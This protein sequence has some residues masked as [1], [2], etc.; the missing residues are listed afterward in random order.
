MTSA[1]AT[2]GALER[3]MDAR[4]LNLEQARL[5]FNASPEVDSIA[6]LPAALLRAGAP[7]DLVARLS[8][9]C[10][11]LLASNVEEGR[12]ETAVA[13]LLERQLSNVRAL[14]V[15]ERLTAKSIARRVREP[16]AV[17]LAGAAEYDAAE[18]FGACCAIREVIAAC[19]PEQLLAPAVRHELR[20]RKYSLLRELATSAMAREAA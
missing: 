5:V 17:L 16:L 2:R 9:L 11:Q 12:C 18:Y 14:P 6:E 7:A 1:L 3:A 13:G 10:R 4:A 15:A 20:D 8:V 19:P